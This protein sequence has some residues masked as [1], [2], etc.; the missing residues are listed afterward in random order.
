MNRRQKIIVS[1]TGIF[2]V[3]LILVGLTYAYFLTK[4]NGNTNDK[5]ISVTTANLILKYDDINDILISEN[6]VEPG[7]SWVKTFSATNKGNKAVTYG[8]ALENLI[9]T[10]ERTEDLVYTLEC[11]Q[12]LKNGYTVTD[13]VPSGTISGT[14]TGIEETEFPTLSSIIVQNTIDDDKVQA[15]TLTVT[16]KEANTNQSV[17]MGK[18]F[19]A[20]VNIVDPNTFGA[21][22]TGTLASTIISSA[23]KGG[24]DRTTWGSKVTEFTSGSDADERVLNSAPDDYGTSYYFRGNVLD[25]NVT[26]AEQNWKI[27]R[28]NGDGSIR[29]VLSTPVNVD[30]TTL[31]K[32]NYSNNDNAYIGYMYGEVGNN[33]D[34]NKCLFVK[35]TEIIDFVIEN[36]ISTYGTKELC[37]SNNGKWTTTAYEATHVNLLESFGKSTVDG[38]YSGAMLKYKDYI[39][40]NIFCNDKSLLEGNGVAQGDTSYGHDIYDPANSIVKPTFECA[41]GVNNDYSRFTSKNNTNDTTIKGVKVNK[42]LTYPAGLLTVDELLFSGYSYDGMRTP[43]TYLNHIKTWTMSPIGYDSSY[44]KATMYTTES[45]TNSFMATT[46]NS[47]DYSIYPVINIK[48]SVLIKSGDGTSSNPYTLKLS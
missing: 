6:A 30:Y 22:G 19:S 29:M 48:S 37:E 3:L 44:D 35:V 31:H 2:L 17:D 8:V 28:I 18:Q 34:E 16:Y 5:S 32:F 43:Y 7:K 27:V 25:N 26:F 13:K 47:K 21:Y 23:Q 38:W 40:E 15:Y 24:E 20:K 10:L 41:K 12:Y 9:N 39:A 36:K 45:N 11:K 1:V 4:I 42:D 46:V 14:C 33:S